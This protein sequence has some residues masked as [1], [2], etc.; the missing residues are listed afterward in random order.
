[1]RVTPAV[2]GFGATP[3]MAGCEGAPATKEVG[4]VGCPD[5]LLLVRREKELVL[6]GWVEGNGPGGWAEIVGLG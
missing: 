6:C 3:A 2:D 1:M 5:Q 4:L